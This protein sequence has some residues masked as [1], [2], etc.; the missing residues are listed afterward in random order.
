MAVRAERKEL[1]Q[2]KFNTHLKEA[3]I[4]YDQGLYREAKEIYLKL[5]S[6]LENMSPTPQ[7]DA[8]KHMLKAKIEEIESMQQK[9]EENVLT[10]PTTHEKESSSEIYEKAQV[11]KELGLYKQAIEEFKKALYKGYK[12]EE[13]IHNIINCYEAQGN[14][15]NAISFLEQIL[16]HPSFSRYREQIK[17]KLGELYEAVGAYGKALNYFKSIKNKEKFPDV[18][19]KIKSLSFRARGGTRF[20]YLLR[21]GI[22]TKEELEDAVTESKKENK[23]VEFILM[24][25]YGVPKE[26]IGKSLS[27]FFGCEFVSFDPSIHIPLDLIRGLKYQY[28]K[29]NGW[30]PLR[31]EENKIIVA[32]DNPHDLSKLDII[33]T[34]L[35]SSDIELVVSIREDIENFIDYFWGQESTPS[36]EELVETVEEVAIDEEAEE[37]SEADSRVIQFVNQMILDA[38]RKKASDIHIEPSPSD[39]ITRIRFRI[40]GICQ[41][42]IQVPNAFT[43]AVV[44][45][46][47]IMA[48]LD[49]AEKRLPQ[50]GKIKFKQ[51]GKDLLELRVATVPTVGGLEDVVLRLLHTGTPLKLNEIGMSERNLKK[52]IDIISQPYGLVLVVGPTGS[53]KTTT[54]HSALSYI[55][56]PDKKIWTAEDPVEI[57]QPG[58]RQVEV[59]PKIGLTFAR[60]MRSFLRADPDVIMIGEMRDEETATIGIEASLTGHLVFSTLHTNSAPETVTRLLEMGLDP[61]N[62]ADSLL[63]VLA[64]RLIRTL[65]KNC[66][67]A[68]HPTKEE[69]DELVAEYGEEY[70]GRVGVKYSGN[71]I[72]YRPKGCDVCGGTGYKGRMGIHELLINDDEIKALIK[73]KAPTEEIRKVAIRQ[74]MTTLKQDGIEKVLKGYTD[75]KEVRRV[76]IK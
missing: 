10:F 34:L 16:N 55:N 28:L 53:G 33:K 29:H 3:E 73:R 58:L 59:R 17:Y 11:F 68:Y 74:G 49:I 51:K 63:G 40:D 72:L 4:Y 19:Q 18:E 62:F 23:S 13:C 48:N 20:D 69:F 9:T 43:R 27:L 65:C 50:D 76:C 66:K 75:L 64:Q 47:K 32:I 2:T 14:K 67:E 30:V 1:D 8:Q 70:F 39:K 38:W 60:I 26:E 12:V 31:R 45:R 52:F 7:I 5:L 41:P 56:T 22:I 6:Q 15:L 35:Q 46:I 42:Y 61:Y 57:T 71:L 24:Q 25:K 36:I 21:E 44:S 37:V 54:L